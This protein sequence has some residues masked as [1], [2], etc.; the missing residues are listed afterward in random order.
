MIE[1]Y[2]IPEMSSI[3]SPES[4]FS[5]WL[6]I[7]I[8]AVE[9]RAEAGLVPA[10]DLK[11][12]R[13]KAGFSVQRINE[14]EKTVRHDVIA[15]LTSV[16][17]TLGPESRHIHYGMTSSDILDTCLATQLRDSGAL[18]MEELKRLG[19]SL[20]ELVRRTRGIVCMGRSHGMFAEP[21]TFGI[22]FA[23]Y[24]S[25]H[26]RVMKR[27]EDGMRAACTGKISGAVGTYAHL[28][29]S[30][31]EYVCSR[32][33]L[34]RESVATQIVARDRHAQFVYA[35]CS[36]TNFLERLGTEV[37]HLQRSE[38]GEA[39]ESFS[40]GQKGSSAMPHKRNP[41]VSERLCG[42]SRLL[43]GYLLS[44]LE[45][46]ALWHERDISHSSAERFIFPDAC[47][48]TLYALRKATALVE[49]LEVF[50]AA[51]M[52][53]LRSAGDRFY[54]QTVLLALIDTGMT[55]EDA[56]A[57]VQ[58]NAMEAMKNGREFLETV[59]D[60]PRI[61]EQIS[62]EELAGRCS[63]EYHL[64]NEGKILG[65]LGLPVEEK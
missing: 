25:E 28:N 62:V 47:G 33:G 20:K 30:V 17:E 50:P 53:N 60:D 38:V 57:L 36:I 16:S 51:A 45:N 49:N 65:R 5:R 9:A 24:L 19:A 58:S 3:W 46:T 29:P 48:I 11:K 27:L 21:T 12:I 4:R 8:L 18:I 64:R 42:L 10:G 15:F 13:E 54:S 6:E 7:E 44:E 14:I 37:R 1:R 2:S 63:L 34:Q 40:K 43:R 26:S 52:D 55:R 32:L 31:E 22:K 23:G 56:Y 39:E 35:L 41:I 59:R 61:M